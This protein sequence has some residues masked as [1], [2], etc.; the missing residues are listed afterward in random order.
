MGCI[1]TSSLHSVPS[2]THYLILL[3][4]SLIL[5]KRR[6]WWGEKVRCYSFMSILLHISSMLLKIFKLKNVSVQW[7]IEFFA[8]FFLMFVYTFRHLADKVQIPLRATS[9]WHSSNASK[10]WP[11]MTLTLHRI[12]II[13]LVVC[14]HKTP[15]C[16]WSSIQLNH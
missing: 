4:I 15:N 3:H 12:I 13:L 9:V 8:V 16:H 10:L 11:Y 1:S 7:K 6:E 14:S 5:S 2:P